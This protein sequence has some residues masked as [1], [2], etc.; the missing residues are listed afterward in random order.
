MKIVDVQTQTF[1]YRS[2][3]VR[4]EDGHGHP[5]PEHDARATVLKIIT[6][7][8]GEGYAFGAN[9][10]VINSVVKPVLL[11]EHPW[12]RERIWKRLEEFQRL[13]KGTL[14][15]RV[16]A[17]VD[18]ALWDLAGRYFKTPVYQLLG[19]KRDKVLAY[20]STM[21]GDELEGGLNTPQAYADFA[22]TCKE[23]GYKA[24]KIHTR[25]PPIP[26]TPN[27]KEDVA[28]CA[29]VREAV[30][31]D[32]ALMVD[33]FHY[34]SREDAYYIGKEL[35]KLDYAWIEE[36][37]DE[38]ST[39]MY[40]WL[41][42]NLKIPVVGP[43]TAEGKMYTR[44]EWI[45][46]N[47][48]DI[49][50]TGVGDVGGLSPAMKCV[51]LAESHGM[52]IEIHGGGA[53]NL[54]VLCAMGIPGAYYERGLLHPFLDYDAPDPWLNEIVDPLDDEGYVHIRQHP[55]LGWNINWDYINANTIK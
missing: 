18:M 15:D 46:R 16:L 4:D 12:Y 53:G 42:E 30:G 13:H 21:C 45:L 31:P 3:T 17:S 54:T 35:E 23:R 14:H 44:A 33:L 41:T 25:M 27:P 24:F 6:D 49:T 39:S 1:H 10:A 8:G 32:M 50:R 2:K 5:G 19:A 22:L 26:G 34:Y 52:S 37:M 28:V 20:A 43:E 38:N 11:G 29:A 9:A 7:D 48:S 40:V 51:H 55:G 47:A 36:P